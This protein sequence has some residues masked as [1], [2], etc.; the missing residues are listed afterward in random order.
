M[1]LRRECIMI[2]KGIRKIDS[3]VIVIGK[4][5]YIEDFIMYKDVLI[6][7]LFRSLYVYVKIKN[8]DI[9]KVEKILGVVG[10]YMYKDVL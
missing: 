3:I 10:I 9:L 4:F 2:N 5:L 1:L 8:I 7:K 6:L